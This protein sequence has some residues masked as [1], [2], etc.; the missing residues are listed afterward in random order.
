MFRFRHW[1]AAPS[2]GHRRRSARAVPHTVND[3]FIITHFVENQI[4]IRASDMSVDLQ[5][6]ACCAAKRSMAVQSAQ[7]FLLAAV[8]LPGDVGDPPVTLDL[9]E[10]EDD[11]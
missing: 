4:W 2:V 9:D 7:C 5:W 6:P 3:D 11:R 10:V 8:P 1:G